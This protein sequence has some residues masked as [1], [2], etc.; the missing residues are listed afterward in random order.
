MSHIEEFLVELH[1][2][3]KNLPRDDDVFPREITVTLYDYFS[4]DGLDF[5]CWVSWGKSL[6][7][8]ICSDQWWRRQLC[9]WAHG[10]EC[11]S[12]E[13]VTLKRQVKNT[14]KEIISHYRRSFFTQ[15]SLRNSW[16]ADKEMMFI[17]VNM[18]LRVPSNLL[19]GKVAVLRARTC[20][21]VWKIIEERKCK[22]IG[23]DR[24]P[25]LFKEYKG[26]LMEEL[27]LAV[28]NYLIEY[29]RIGFSVYRSL[30]K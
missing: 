10:D 21:S 23:G 9:R 5:R 17:H 25:E 2:I 4:D 15:K 28:K 6:D 14:Y 27:G 11:G 19:S 29:P 30:M 8:R 13:Y 12:K 7:Y 20:E 3:L 16:K 22:E 26:A 18:E 24:E 1:S